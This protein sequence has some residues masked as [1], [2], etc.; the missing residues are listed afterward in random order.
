MKAETG[1]TLAQEIC[2]LQLFSEELGAKWRIHVLWALHD[3]NGCRY[4]MVKTRIPGITDMMLTQSLKNL[5]RYGYISREQF[6]ESPPRVE[7]QI[8]DLGKTVLPL[9]SGMIEWEKKNRPERF[10]ESQQS[11]AQP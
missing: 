1:D 9:L 2:A 7:Y 3:G 10:L 6:S 5:Q 11:A 4:S 8:T